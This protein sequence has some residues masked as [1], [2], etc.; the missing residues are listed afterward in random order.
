MQYSVVHQPPQEETS[1]EF[2]QD[3]RNLINS[4]QTFLGKCKRFC[5]YETPKVISLAWEI[6]IE[7]E[8]AFE[9]KQYQPEGILE[10][11]RK[12]HDDVQNIRE[13]LAEYINTP[14]WNRPIV[15]YD[16]DDDEDY[17]I[18]NTPVLSTNEPVDSLRMEDEHLD[19]IPATESNEVIKSNQFEGFS[20]S[21]DDSTSIDDDYFSIDDIDYVEAST[22]DF[23]LVSLEEIE[24][25]NSN[26][27]P[28]SSFVTKS[29][30]TF[31]NSF[32]EETNT[33]DNSISEFET[34]CFNLEENSSGSTT[35]H[36][37]ISLSKYD[38]FIFD[39]LNDPFPPVDR[40]DF[41]HKE[42]ADELAHIISPPKYDCF[43]SKSEP[44]LGELTSIVDFG[45]RENVLS[46]TNMNLPFEDDQP[47]LLAYVV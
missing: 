14:N 17:T 26:P 22:P 34:F 29:P 5:F 31:P 32:L 9:D 40:S 4:M 33:F 47:P 41:Y 35:T 30:S 45:I 27:P 8:R 10:L 43:Y 20:D 19:T 3:Q 39:L 12:L 37:D 16:D 13:E 11:F 2:L 18:A 28:S 46:M 6:I 25:I 24:A 1:L 44:D 15:Y 7:I 21:N 38:S 23:E 36:S 42:F